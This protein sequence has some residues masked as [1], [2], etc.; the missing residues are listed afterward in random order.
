MSFLGGFGKGFAMGYNADVAATKAAELEASKYNL[1]LT[2]AASQKKRTDDSANTINFGV[3]PTGEG[4]NYIRA[5]NSKGATQHAD[6]IRGL[7][8]VT[9]LQ[10]NLI[11]ETIF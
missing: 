11:M 8:T 5:Y 7:N 10:K 4:L 3:L 9:E 2:A 1:Q 6:N